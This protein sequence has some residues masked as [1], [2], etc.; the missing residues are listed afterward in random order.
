[1][2]LFNMH[3]DRPG[4][5]VD[6]DTPRKKGAARFVE[7]VG[8]DLTSFWLAGLLT[9]LSAVPFVF[10]VWFSIVS[11]AVL[12]ALLAGV[13]G[14]MIAAP[15]ICGLQDVMLRSLRDEPGFWWTTYRRVWKRNAKAS[16]LPGAIGGLILAMQ[17]FSL[18]HMDAGQGAMM[19]VA[20]LLGLIFLTGLAQYIFAQ[21]ALLDLPFGVVLK[22]AVLMF[23]GY[24]PRTML[25]VLWQLLYWGVFALFWPFTSVLLVITGSWL[26]T[27]LGLMAI[28]PVLD[29]S[30]HV[31]ERISQMREEDLNKKRNDQ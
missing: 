19:M 29:K 21:I 26:P 30:F 25:G 3:Y 5:G 8:R 12:P 15:Q 31:E 16:L 6:P 24:L 20:L 22:N 10:G 4:P 13:L 7:V 2:S 1:M 14:G 28:Y 27:L 9:M 11:H 18:Y 23:L 17:I